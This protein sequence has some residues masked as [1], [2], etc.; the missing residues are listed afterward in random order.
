MGSALLLFLTSRSVVEIGADFCKD[1]RGRCLA[2]RLSSGPFFDG[3]SH[4]RRKRGTCK[5]FAVCRKLGRG[6]TERTLVRWVD[7]AMA[8]H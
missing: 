2:G 3:S 1:A 7:R 4:W 5:R 6:S 8:H